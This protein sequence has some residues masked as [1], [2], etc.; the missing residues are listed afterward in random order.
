M[1]RATTARALHALYAFVFLGQAPFSPRYR[2]GEVGRA[3]VE[4]FVVVLRFGYLKFPT[5]ANFCE[6]RIPPR[7]LCPS[8]ANPPTR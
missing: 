3:K 7:L 2:E 8:P 6:A 5:R 4:H 1:T